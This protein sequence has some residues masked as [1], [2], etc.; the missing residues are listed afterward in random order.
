MKSEKLILK[1][2]IDFILREED[3][4]EL[5]IMLQQKHIIQKEFLEIMA[6]K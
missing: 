3:S 5:E 4:R 6:R 2:F 1:I